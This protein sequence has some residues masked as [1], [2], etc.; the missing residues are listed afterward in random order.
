MI[1]VTRTPTPPTSLARQT[2]GCYRAPDVVT[3]LHK[4]FHGKCYLCERNEVQSPEV[5]HLIAHG[6][7]STLK[8][9]WNNLFF[10]CSHCNSV[11]NQKKFSQNVIDCCNKDPEKLIEPSF[12]NNHVKVVPLN[13]T[14]EA[15]TTA[16]LITECFENVNTGIRTLERKVLINS[17]NA[18]MNVFYKTLIEYKSNPSQEI[19]DELSTM[20]SR[21][22]KFAG[23]TRAYVRANLATYPALANLV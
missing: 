10:S 13:T 14:V 20:L 4:D 12:I 1:K 22:Y 3:Q 7:N 19:L 18:T 11:K 15:I 23:F 5:E 8:Y 21:T 9:D 16:E 2:N 6:G 17:L